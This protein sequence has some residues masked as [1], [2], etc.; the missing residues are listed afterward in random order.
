MARL[1]AYLD[2]G[3]GSMIVGAVA[4]A[5]A[6]VAVAARAFGSRVF[7]RGAKS[8]TDVVPEQVITEAPIAPVVEP[9]A[10]TAA[11]PTSED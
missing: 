7:R 10:A 8:P 9:E 1:V 4:A 5:G 6:S 3:T 2:P 11:A